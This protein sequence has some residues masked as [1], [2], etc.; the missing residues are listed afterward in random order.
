[1]FGRIEVDIGFHLRCSR[2]RLWHVRV[3]TTDSCRNSL[4]LKLM[5]ND[6]TSK[7]V[8]Q[9]PMLKGFQIWPP[10]CGRTRRYSFCP[11][12][13]TSIHLIPFCCCH[14]HCSLVHWRSRSGS[15]DPNWN[16]LQQQTEHARQ[17]QS[18]HL[19]QTGEVSFVNLRNDFLD[20]RLRTGYG[21]LRYPTWALWS[22]YYHPACF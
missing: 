21:T 20:L 1:M 9:H 10:T 8:V 14:R 16:Y 17:N 15:R 22:C 2:Y 13:C 18:S 3:W 11:R 5:I 19:V 6:R 7:K 12:S 4:C